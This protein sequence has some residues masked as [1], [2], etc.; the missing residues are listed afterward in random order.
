MVADGGIGTYLQNIVPRVAASRPG[1][2]FTFLGDV[3]R[4]A[5]LGWG[6]LPNAELRSC[7]AG[8]YSVA[9]Q[10]EIV[11][12]CPA[13]ANLY[14]AP[15]YNIPLFMRARPLVVTV[16]DVCHLALPELTGGFLRRSYARMMFQSV[17]RRARGLLFVSEFSRNEMNRLVGRGDNGAL[18][19]VSHNAVDETWWRA[20][21]LAPSRPIAEPYFVYVG[22]MKRHKNV[23]A[24]LRAFRAVADRV[25]HKLVIIGRRE[26]LRADPAIEPEARQLGERVLF[27]GEIDNPDLRRYV[28]H[29]H[30]FVTA[31]LYEGFGLAPLEAMAAGCPCVVS[32]AG[33]LPETCGD[34]AL[35]CD[36][37]SERSITEK[38]LQIATEEE[39][40]QRLIARGRERAKQFT[41]ER[42]AER[43]ATL[44]ER[45][46]A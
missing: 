31:S 36:P 28:A 14:W 18:S 21:E 34:A 33:S 3:D 35:Y 7:R 13:D 6:K 17:R 38:L 23:P 30:A 19:V 25:P 45:A 16:H 12:R 2:R 32:T 43:T 20:R 11:L 41:W 40:R 24:L 15:H 46:L 22:N 29:A 1:W 5:A 37:H 44:L 9:E 8:I 27:T 4:L 42:S 10:L 26:G 39:T